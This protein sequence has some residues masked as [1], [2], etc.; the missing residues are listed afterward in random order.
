MGN[1]W[2][3]PEPVVIGEIRHS[4][5]GF[6]SQSLPRSEFGDFSAWPCRY[7]SNTVLEVLF[8]FLSCRY[9]SAE[10]ALWGQDTSKHPKA[11]A[12]HYSWSLALIFGKP[13]RITPLFKKLFTQHVKKCNLCR[14][15]ICTVHLLTVV[16]FDQLFCTCKHC[17]KLR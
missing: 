13:K 9:W 12:Y 4:P 17:E 2:R 16:D 1:V 6:R 14:K 8:F 10:H 5:V 7:A 3:R 11:L 15:Q